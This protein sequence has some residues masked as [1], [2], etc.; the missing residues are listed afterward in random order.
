[1]SYEPGTLEPN[2]PFQRTPCAVFYSAF[3][4][5]RYAYVPQFPYYGA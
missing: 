4:W 3:A 2:H 5:D 1:M